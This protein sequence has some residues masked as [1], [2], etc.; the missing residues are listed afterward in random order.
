MFDNGNTGNANPFGDNTS[1]GFNSFPPQPPQRKNSKLWIIPVA[2][3]GTIAAIA[4]IVFSVWTINL[5]QQNVQQRNGASQEKL[6]PSDE[7]AYS[8]ISSGD[9]EL[10]DLNNAGY[11]A[12]SPDEFAYFG[13]YPPRSIFL[14]DA[15]SDGSTCGLW[16]YNT[17]T[18]ALVAEAGQGFNSEYTIGES[19]ANGLGYVLLADSQET[20]C[21][22]QAFDYLGYGR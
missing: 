14:S 4:A 17:Y 15:G 11:V 7:E 21:A 18:E 13:D 9:P 10:D 8:D 5:T 1:S 12:W 3:I 2:I 22:V 19:P 20:E 16:L 6:A